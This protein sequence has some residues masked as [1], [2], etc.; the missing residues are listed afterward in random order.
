MGLRLPV[1]LG[2]TLT[3]LGLVAWAALD[4]VLVTDN[5]M[6]PSV[7]TGDWL[8]LGPGEPRVG[9]VVAVDDPT[10]PGLTVYRR[11][12]GLAGNQ[13]AIEDGLVVADGQRLALKEMGR[14]EHSLYLS[15][16][17]GWLIRHPPRRI[18]LQ[19]E[20]RT[21][22]PDHLY[23]LADDRIGA[24]DSRWWGPVPAASVQGVVWL[25]IGDEGTWR[26]R[27]ARWARDGP[28]DKP[29][30]EDPPPPR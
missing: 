21:V 13:I 17:N 2:T 22:P 20:A 18:R 24:L 29:R 19:R 9:Q 12:L 6:T 1:L 11:V 15:E 25:R 8:L 5:E 28:W 10:W 27:V 7:Q 3:A 14:D 16:D 4:L 30:P 23:L 26:G